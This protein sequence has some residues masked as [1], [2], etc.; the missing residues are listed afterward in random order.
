VTSPPERRTPCED[1]GAPLG[2]RAG[3]D[4]AFHALGARAM[5]DSAFAYRRRAVV[6]AYALQHPAYILSLK[7]FAA[8]VCGLCAAVERSADPRAERAIW[9]DLA[10]PPG[11]TKPAV[12][13]TR[14]TLTIAGVC[15]AAT[16]ESFR[17]AVDVWIA[18]VWAAWEIHHALARGWLDY[19][20]ANRSRRG[21][22]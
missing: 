14:G 5:Q 10:I 3:C 22:P 1:C 20:I 18:D 2:G 12:P 19:A 9:S 13:D 15:T 11:S 8:H 4:A 21:A 7:S 6:D 17:E 16:P